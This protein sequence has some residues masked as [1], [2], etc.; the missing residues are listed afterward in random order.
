MI[1][2]L[3]DGCCCAIASRR[4]RVRCF[5]IFILIELILPLDRDARIS[6]EFS[7]FLMMLFDRFAL[8]GF[9]VPVR[10]LDLDNFL[11]LS[12]T[13][14]DIGSAICPRDTYREFVK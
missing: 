2:G 13:T 6:V 7:F 14:S 1:I 5:P 10:L 3:W 4:G 8:D 12:V 9:V 11:V